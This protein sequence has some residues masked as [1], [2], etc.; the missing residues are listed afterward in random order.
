MHGSVHD[1]WKCAFSPIHLG[2]EGTVRSTVNCD[3]LPAATTSA[4]AVNFLD[5][6]SS[7][8]GPSPLLPT[9]SQLGWTSAPVR[10]AASHSNA[11]RSYLET[12]SA[13]GV[14]GASIIRSP[15]RKR[16]RL[17]RGATW[18][19]VS[20]V[21]SSRSKSA[22]T[23][24]DSAETNSPQTRCRGKSFASNNP[25]LAPSRAAVIAQE[26][27]AGPPPTIAR[28]NWGSVFSI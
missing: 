10:R 4:F 16:V 15:R 20:A 7:T 9:I 5:D 28:S 26:L 18:K 25:T 22:R 6:V 24:S 17:I 21:D 11:S 3:H 27:P 12:L 23:S 8:N 13:G 14:T 2:P 19:R 1:S